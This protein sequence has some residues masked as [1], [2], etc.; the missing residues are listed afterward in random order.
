M[1]NK[2]T[3]RRRFRKLRSGDALVKDQL[4]TKK[5]IELYDVDLVG[6]IVADPYAQHP[7]SLRV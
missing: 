5:S 7:K 2:S 4:C 3:Y 1:V 6:L